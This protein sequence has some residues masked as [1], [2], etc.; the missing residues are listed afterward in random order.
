MIVK[1]CVVRIELN[2]RKG[3]T[4]M[5]RWFY[6]CDGTVAPYDGIINHCHETV[7]HYNDTAEHCDGTVGHCDGTIEHCHGRVR[8]DHGTLQNCDSSKEFVWGQG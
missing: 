3:F 5:E 1:H 8:H 4:G 7:G 2:D 6:H